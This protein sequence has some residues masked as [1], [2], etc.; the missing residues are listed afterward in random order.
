MGKLVFA[1]ETV[2]GKIDLLLQSKEKRISKL[3][4]RRKYPALLAM[5]VK[6]YSSEPSIKQ[7]YCLAQHSHKMIGKFQISAT[8]GFTEFLKEMK[9]GLF[10][11]SQLVRNEANWMG[12]F[13]FQQLSLSNEQDFRQIL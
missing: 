13:P 3:R 6:R 2:K 4:A 9:Q 11:K 12:R 10:L 5:F 8:K 1:V 7:Y